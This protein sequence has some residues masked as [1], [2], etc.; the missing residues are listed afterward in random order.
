LYVFPSPLTARPG[1]VCKEE[2]LSY[3]A[4]W[5]G[6]NPHRTGKILSG[7]NPNLVCGKRDYWEREG[8]L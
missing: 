6:K 2:A 7:T 4:Y 3:W 1:F 5:R 8:C